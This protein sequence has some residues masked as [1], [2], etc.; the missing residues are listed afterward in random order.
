MGYSREVYDAAMA[1][2]NRRRTRAEGEAQERRAAFYALFPRAREIQGELAHLAAGTAKAVFGGSG[3]AQAMER[4]R[5][6]SLA[7]QKERESLL[8]QAGLEK[9]AL[10]PA[11]TCGKC[12]DT[13][14]IDGRMCNCLKGLLRQEA[15]RRLNEMT[16]LTLSGF[17]QFD[18]RYYS[19]RG[20]GDQLSPRAHMEQVLAFCRQYA[21]KFSLHSESLLFQGRTGLGKT[22]LSLAIAREAIQKGYGVVY[23]SVQNF[24]TALEKERFGRDGGEG[25]QDTNQMLLHCDLLILDDLGTEFSTAFVT[26]ALYNIIN[27]RLMAEKPTVISTNLSMKELLDRYG[28]RMVSRMIGGYQRILF[29]GRDVRQL[30]NME[31]E[32]SREGL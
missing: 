25:R 17:E 14:F 13:G 18:L 1:E 9:D 21:E 7:L 10:K 30:K 16:P 23:G 2:L 4:L 27:T 8:Q 31:R 15:Y 3:A 20:E 6:K 26:T 28:E 11:Y 22:H 12:Q 29:A 5:N 19:D 24:V 32:R